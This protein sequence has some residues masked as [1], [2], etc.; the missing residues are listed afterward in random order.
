MVVAAVVAAAVAVAALALAAVAAVAVV[1]VAVVAVVA[2][3]VVVVVAVAT[4]VAAVVAA[5]AVDTEQEVIAFWAGFIVGGT[6]MI[7]LFASGTLTL[8]KVQSQMQN[9]TTTTIRQPL[10]T[11]SHFRA[12]S[13]RD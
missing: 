4:V 10:S 3:A 2:V 6:I 1:A 7:I 5:V 13:C 8:P 12:V 11:P 9:V